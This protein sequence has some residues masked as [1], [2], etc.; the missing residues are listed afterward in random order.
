MAHV[1]FFGRLRDI[2]GAGEIAVEDTRSLSALRARLA[3]ENAALGDA[4]AA[5][6]VIVAVDKAIRHD[7]AAL[8][9]DSEVAFMRPLSGG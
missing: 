7:D 3:A 2:A 1:L 4:L 6:G 5:P 9:D 8:T